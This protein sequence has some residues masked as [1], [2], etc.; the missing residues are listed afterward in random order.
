MDTVKLK[1]GE[2]IMVEDIDNMI[3]IE[4][5][6]VGNELKLIMAQNRAILEMNTKILAL[7]CTVRYLVKP[8][9]EKS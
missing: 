3:S 5:V 4:P 7:Q 9:K 6:K 1:P 8:G 2:C